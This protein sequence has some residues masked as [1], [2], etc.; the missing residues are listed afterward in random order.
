MRDFANAN[1]SLTIGGFDGPHLGHKS[2]FDSVLNFASQQKSQQKNCVAGLVTF[3]FSPRKVLQQQKFLGSVSTLNLRLN[4]F[5]KMGFDFVIVID[6]SLN[7]GKMSGR[8]FFN[9]LCSICN[10][11]HLVVGKDFCCGYQLDTDTNQ[12]AKIAEQNGF[13]LQVADDVTIDGKRISSSLL[14]N[15]ILRG[16]LALANKF[17]GYNFALDAQSLKQECLSAKEIIFSFDQSFN[18][19]M[20][21]VGQYKVCIEIAHGKSCQDSVCNS[22]Y[23]GVLHIQVDFL[24]CYLDEE[25]RGGKVQTIRF[26]D[27][28]QKI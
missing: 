17:L 1:V 28:T 14:R 5:C 25:Y 24:R 22:L 19:V 16:E 9:Q 21:P 11:A 13:C 8:A 10:L 3:V 7:F 4:A 15:F 27:I 20:P 12:I 2:L 26:L 23:Y 18:Q 6:F